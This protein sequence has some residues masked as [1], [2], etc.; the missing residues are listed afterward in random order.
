MQTGELESTNRTLPAESQR[1]SSVY[2][3]KCK[4]SAF[5]GEEGKERSIFSEA[6]QAGKTREAS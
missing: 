1:R 3:F 6:P 5:D 4:K 2:N